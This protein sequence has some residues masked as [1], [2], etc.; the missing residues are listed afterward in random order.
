M[1]W[2]LHAPSVSIWAVDGRQAIPFVCGRRQWELLQTRRGETDLV[3]LHGQFY[4]LAVCDVEEPTP[5]AVAGVIG[6]D[7]GIVTITTD[8]DGE[9]H[10]GQ[11]IDRVRAR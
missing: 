6:V 8:S 4:L 2:N 1:S 10:S 3:S 7:L 11:Q 5:D 9:S